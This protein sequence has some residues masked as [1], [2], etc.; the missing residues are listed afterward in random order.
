MSFAIEYM[1]HLPVQGN[2]L[3]VPYD[4]GNYTVGFQSFTGKLHLH[5]G[6]PRNIPMHAFLLVE[7]KIPEGVEDYAALVPF[8]FLQHVRMMPYHCVRSGV[9]RFLRIRSEE[10]TSELQS[11]FH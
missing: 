4:S 6:A 1:L 5:Y 8:Y 2:R 9:D 7:D 11:Q 10:H 3:P